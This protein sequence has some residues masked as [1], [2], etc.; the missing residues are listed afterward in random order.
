MRVDA[1]VTKILVRDERAV[2]V[3]L[4]SGEEIVARRVVSSLDPRRTLIDL[5]DPLHLAPEFRRRVQNIRMRGLLA[6]VNYAVDAVPSIAAAGEAGG[7]DE[8]LD[9]ERL[10]PAVHRDQPD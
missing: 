7:S 8:S 4:T 9:A 2:G 6:K 3:V 1:G 10:H 5:V